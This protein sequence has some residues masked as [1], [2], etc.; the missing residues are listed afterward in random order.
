MNVLNALTVDVE[1][2]FQVQAFANVVRPEQWDHFPLRVES[3]TLRMLELF[4]QYKVRA[5]FFVLGWVADRCP[6]LVRQIAS[7]GHEVGCHGYSHKMIGQED[8]NTFRE[9]I[10]R[11][12]SILENLC[13]VSVRCYRAPSYSVTNRTLW[14]LDVLQSVG[15]EYDSSIFPIVHDRYGIPTAPRFPYFHNLT[16]CRRILEFPPSTLS[17]SGINLPIAGGGYFRMLPYHATAWALHRIN[18]K[19]QQPIMFYLHPWEIDPAQPRIN[20]PWSSRFRHYH[21]LQSTETKLC[22]LLKEFS[23]APMTEVA[24][25]ALLTPTAR[26]ETTNVN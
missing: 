7:A 20:A 19:E 24:K 23:W 11:A 13:A 16:D 8:E 17:I 14:A 10:R 1:D 18:E 9:D 4:S 25:L 26:D 6:G 15:F 2:Y 5:T 12:K 21:N 3:N 22:R